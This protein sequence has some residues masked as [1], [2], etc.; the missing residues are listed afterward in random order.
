MTK[1]AIAKK[2]DSYK[3]DIELYN[4]EELQNQLTEINAKQGIGSLA[5]ITSIINNCKLYNMI[6]AS[7]TVNDL[8][9]VY[10]ITQ[11]NSQIFKSLQQY[12]IVPQLQ[13]KQSTT[14]KKESKLDRLR[15]E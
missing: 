15:S 3:V 13:R 11:L 6:I 12:G 4:S 9:Q 1:E 8:K 5:G 2:T 14:T 7:F 10:I